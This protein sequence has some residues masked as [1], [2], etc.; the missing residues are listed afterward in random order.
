[1]LF[2]SNPSS[3]LNE[4]DIGNN[5]LQDSGVEL[6]C[7]G[8]QSQQSSLMSLRSGF[9]IFFFVFAYDLHHTP[10]KMKKMMLP[11]NSR[12]GHQHGLIKSFP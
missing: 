4:L 7:A 12:H 1:M 5:A 6:I 11:S 8:L 3:R 10:E 2:L 9:E